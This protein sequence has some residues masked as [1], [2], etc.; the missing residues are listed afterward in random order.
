M[1][2]HHHHYRCCAPPSLSEDHQRAKEARTELGPLSC[3][4]PASLSSPPPATQS[5]SI[6][7]GGALLS[8]RLQAQG[9]GRGQRWPLGAPPRQGREAACGE[10]QRAQR[11]PLAQGRAIASPPPH[12]V[13]QGEK[14]TTHPWPESPPPSGRERILVQGKGTTCPD[15]RCSQPLLPADPFPEEV[16]GKDLSPPPENTGGP[17]R[18][19][20]E[21]PRFSLS[22]SPALFL[23]PPPTWPEPRSVVPRSVGCC[24]GGGREGAGRGGIPP[25]LLKDHQAHL[26]TGGGS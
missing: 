21:G 3:S 24:Q 26:I 7:P 13:S 6:L 18:K 9:G 15:G 2:G 8:M 12:A 20:T 14:P 16:A 19:G 17:L 1:G 11:V 23:T 10:C 5:S 22:L 25:A 4:S